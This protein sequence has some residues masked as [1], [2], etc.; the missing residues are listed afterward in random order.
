M[1]AHEPQLWRALLKTSWQ[2]S[3][4]KLARVFN[5]TRITADDVLDVL[6]SAEAQRSGRIF[7][8]RDTESN[9]PVFPSAGESFDRWSRR[10]HPEHA[11]ARFCL[12]AV[13]EELE[14][15]VPPPILAALVGG[16]DEVLGRVT[17]KNAVVFAG[18]YDFTPVGVHTD[19]EPIVQ[20]VISGRKRAYF[21]S[22]EVWERA[23]RNAKE[24]DRYLSEAQVFELEAGDLVYWPEG[25]Y[26]IFKSL[27]LS[28]AISI[29]FPDETQPTTTPS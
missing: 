6:R 5:P 4:A 23:P 16:L 9:V 19:S 21:W 15:M 11:G 10:V 20:A 17:R 14:V 26:H 3:P 7:L 8:N 2:R 1:F 18:N 25:Q 27:E 28:T 24:P 13:A 22:P 29:G 12:R